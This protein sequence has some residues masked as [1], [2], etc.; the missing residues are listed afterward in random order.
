MARRVRGL[1]ETPGAR[2]LKDLAHFSLLAA[3]LPFTL[4]EAACHAGSTIMIEARKAP[5]HKA[6]RQAPLHKAARKA[7]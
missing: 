2:L 5:L 6:A 4:L 7:P 1:P 3:A